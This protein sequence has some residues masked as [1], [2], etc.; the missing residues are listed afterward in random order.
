MKQTGA[1]TDMRNILLSFLKRRHFWRYATFSEV[2]ELYISRMLRMAGIYTSASFVSIYLYQAGYSVVY[3]LLFWASYFAIKATLALPLA[4]YAAHYGPKHGILLS[5]LLYIPAM[6]LYPLAGKYGF[7]ILAVAGLLQGISSTLYNM[8]YYIDFSKVK[9][10]EHAGKEIAYMNIFEKIATGLSPLI[11]GCLALWF[12]PSITLWMSAV[13]FTLA[14]GPLMRTGEVI[15]TRQKLVFRGFPWRMAWRSIVANFGV[16][17][18]NTSSGTIWSL[19]VAL[20][21]IGISS[22]NQVYAAI[23]G[24]ASLIVIADLV[25]SYVYGLLIDRRRGGELLKVGLAADALTHFARPM[26]QTVFAAGLIN[27]ANEASTT[28]YMMAFT[29]G[30]FDVADRTGHR[31]TYIAFVE[32]MQDVGACVAAVLA[33]LFVLKFGADTGLR[34]YYWVAGVV[35]L[36]MMIARFPLYRR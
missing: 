1:K 2:G 35:V 4:K 10:A 26:T 3:I 14:A 18:D 16:G 21:I 11:G 32:A 29:R 8:C 19:L 25:F 9:T 34:D 27:V 5:N 17:F 6:V 24:L 30:M 12:G 22:N 31:T 23:G 28:G 20:A 13:L 36:G 33:A 7:S 15:E